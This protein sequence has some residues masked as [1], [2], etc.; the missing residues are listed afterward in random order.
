MTHVLCNRKGDWKLQKER[1][2]KKIAWPVIIAVRL[3]AWIPS[4]T[5]SAVVDDPYPLD[6][7]LPV[8]KEKIPFILASYNANQE[9][10]K[11]VVFGILRDK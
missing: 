4:V 2:K 5:C 6:P 1:K 8:T 11:F 10:T 3:V 9:Q 7:G